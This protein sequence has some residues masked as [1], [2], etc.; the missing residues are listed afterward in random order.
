M[1]IA[2]LVSTAISTDLPQG[3]DQEP[4]YFT[5]TAA[6]DFNSDENI[7]VFVIDTLDVNLVRQAFTDH[8]HLWGYLD[9]FTF[10]ENNTSEYF[11]TTAS[12][13]SMLTQHHTL[14]WEW[15]WD[16]LRDAWDRH[17][18]IDTL[19]ENNFSTNLFIDRIC[20]FYRYEFIR[21]RTD[22]T[23]IADKLRIDLRHFI[24]ITTRLALGR[25]SPYLMKN[26]WISAISPTF[27]TAFYSLDVD[28]EDA[29]F[30]PAVTHDTEMRFHRFIKN[31]EFSANRE[32]SFFMFMHLNG[33]HSS[34]DRNDPSSWGYHYDS[35]SGDLKRGGDMI[36]IVHACFEVLE[37]YFNKMK[38]IGV[39]DNSTIIIVG[40]HGL[41]WWYPE[42]TALLIKPK[43]STG[44]LEVDSV[45]PLSHLYFPASILDAAGI[46]RDHFNVSYFDLI[47]EL[48]HVPPKRVLYVKG[49]F[50]TTPNARVYGDYGIWEVVGDANEAEN[51]T[52]VPWDPWDFFPDG[53]YLHP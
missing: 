37:F 8:P 5:Q 41:R 11:D 13:T 47:N 20:T 10:Y 48:K 2:G 18:L 9:G 36:D 35:L 28:D 17:T 19:R 7:I 29:I 6:V 46:Q 16:Y 26:T 32:E 53:I 23:E 33:P 21:G 14:P 12:T 27:S 34:G 44:A 39:Y 3:Y 22:N 4:V 45:T 42:T 25:M 40:D 49:T 52:F 50:N 51:W 43:G 24:P 38:E 1:Q 15:G 31:T 30:V